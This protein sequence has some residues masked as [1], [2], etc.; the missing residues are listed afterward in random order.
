MFPKSHVQERV[1]AASSRKLGTA[2]VSISRRMGNPTGG[3]FWKWT[4]TQ[5]VTRNKQLTEAKTLKISNILWRIL[6]AF[7]KTRKCYNTHVC[8]IAP[9]HTCMYVYIRLL[10][11]RTWKVNHV[12]GGEWLRWSETGMGTAQKGP[13]GNFLEWWWYLRRLG[14]DFCKEPDAKYFSLSGPHTVLT[15]YSSLFV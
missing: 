1:A 10:N 13:W 2:Q 5:Q 3:I 11:A 8:G 7:A 15:V 14:K 9:V 4:S 12:W 6:K